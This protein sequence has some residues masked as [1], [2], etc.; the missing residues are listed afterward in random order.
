MSNIKNKC[1]E[2]LTTAVEN[3]NSEK[4]I[5]ICNNDE[6]RDCIKDVINE[7]RGGNDD[8]IFHTIANSFNN[9]SANVYKTLIK[10]GAD[11]TIKNDRG[12]T[13]V[14][15]LRTKQNDINE[16]KNGEELSF[17]FENEEKVYNDIKEKIN[18]IEG[19]ELNIDSEMEE[20]NYDNIQKEANNIMEQQEVNEEKSDTIKKEEI[21][22]VPI[23][24]NKNDEKKK[25]NAEILQKINKT[26]E[27]LLSEIK[28]T[29]LNAYSVISEELKSIDEKDT[30]LQKEFVTGVLT[31]KD[32]Y[33]STLIELASMGNY[34]AFRELFY[35]ALE[36]APDVV[37]TKYFNGNTIL[38]FACSFNTTDN[39]YRPLIGQSEIVEEILNK[40]LI[41]IETTNNDNE[42][43]L[44]AA[45][46]AGNYKMVKLLV[47]KNANVSAV[48]KNNETPLFA[49]CRKGDLETMK[50]LVNNGADIFT[51]NKDGKNLFECICSDN[52]VGDRSKIE[53]FLN[54]EVEKKK[55]VLYEEIND[56]IK[57]GN[58]YNKIKDIIENI[59]NEEYVQ[60]ILQREDTRSGET[61]LFEA[62][63]K[64][65]IDTVKLL[66]ERGANVFKM[67]RTNKGILDITTNNEV[68][69]YIQNIKAKQYY[70]R[71]HKYGIVNTGIAPVQFIFENDKDKQSINLALQLTNDNDETL[72]FEACRK[73]D[74]AL[75]DSL[76]QYGAGVNV[77]NK[78]GKTVID[79]LEKD[80]DNMNKKIIKG[81]IQEYIKKNEHNSKRDIITGDLQDIG[82]TEE[83]IENLYN[84]ISNYVRDGNKTELI[85]TLNKSENKPYIKQALNTK[86]TNGD[87]IFQLACRNGFDNDTLYLLAQNGADIF[88]RNNLNKDALDNVN[89]PTTKQYLDELRIQKIKSQAEEY[90]INKDYYNLSLLVR[91]HGETLWKQTTEEQLLKNVNENE[92]DIISNIFTTQLI[93]DGVNQYNAYDKALECILNQDYYNLSLILNK[94]R[95]DIIEKTHN[96]DESVV[97]NDIPEYFAN[98]SN[99]YKKQKTN[100]GFN[101]MDVAYLCNDDIVK[102]ILDTSSVYKNPIDLETLDKTTKVN[103]YRNIIKFYIEN[104]KQEE[105]KTILKNTDRK[106]F[107][108]EALNTVDKNGETLLFE[109]CKQ[110]NIEIVELLVENGADISATNNSNE[111]P[112][113]EACRQGNIEIVELLVKNGA[114]ISV[115]NNNNET[116]LFEACRQQNTEVIDLLVKNGADVT[117][118]NNEGKQI[119][120]YVDMSIDG[121]CNKY[122]RNLYCRNYNDAL[123]N[124]IKNNTF[125]EK[126]LNALSGTDYKDEI[127]NLQDNNGETLLF[128]ACKQG[129]IKVIDFLIKNGA[130]IY[131]QDLDDKNIFDHIDSGK[132][133][134]KDGVKKYLIG[135]K[136]KDQEQLKE[137]EQE[138]KQDDIL[139]NNAESDF[140]QY[141]E[142]NLEEEQVEQQMEQSTQDEE[143]L[144]QQLQQELK[145]NTEI[146]NNQEKVIELYNNIDKLIKE[147]KYGEIN[148]IINDEKNR[149]FIR[150]VLKWQDENGET[151]L[152]QACRSGN[153]QV[154]ELLLNKE[155]EFGVKSIGILNKDGKSI[156]NV[157]DEEIKRLGEENSS[158]IKVV[159]GYIHGYVD[160]Y[161]K[162]NMPLEWSEIGKDIKYK[163]K[164]IANNNDVVT[165]K[166]AQQQVYQIA[167]YYANNS[168]INIEQ[169]KTYAISD[170]H[171]DMGALLESLLRSGIVEFVNPEE[172]CIVVVNNDNPD[173]KILIPN[174]K[175]TENSNGNKLVVLGDII[176]RGYQSDSCMMLMKHLMNQQTQQKSNNIIFTVGNHEDVTINDKT[177]N[178]YFLTLDENS[179]KQGENKDHN[180]ARDIFKDMV[181]QN[182][183]LFCYY[184]ESTNTIYSHVP[185]DIK[186]TV[187]ALN[188]IQNNKNEF[189]KQTQ[190]NIDEILNGL[191]KNPDF[192]KDNKEG[193]KRLVDVFNELYKYKCEYGNEELHYNI[194][195]KEDNTG[196]L[197]NRDYTKDDFEAIPGINCVCGHDPKKDDSQEVQINKDGSIVNVDTLR[198]CG[199][200][201]DKNKVGLVEILQGENGKLSHKVLEDIGH[202]KYSEDLKTIET[203]N[204]T[205][206]VILQNNT[207]FIKK[208]I[209]SLVSKDLSKQEIQTDNVKQQ[210]ENNIKTQLTKKEKKE[211]KKE[212]KRAEKQQKQE[213]KEIKKREKEEKKEQKNKE[214]MQNI[215]TSGGRDSNNQILSQRKQRHRFWRFIKRIIDPFHLFFK[216]DD[217]S[218]E[219]HKT[220]TSYYSNNYSSISHSYPEANKTV[221]KKRGIK[222]FKESVQNMWKKHKEN[223][224]IK[225]EIKELNKELIKE[226]VNNDNRI[227][228]EK[229][230]GEINAIYFNSVAKYTDEQYGTNSLKSESVV[231]I[232]E[233]LQDKIEKVTKRI[234]NYYKTY[235]STNEQISIDEGTDKR[236]YG[237]EMY[238]YAMLNKLSKSL[239]G[240]DTTDPK[241]NN[242]NF[243]KEYKGTIKKAKKE[244][245]S[246][247]SM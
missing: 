47:E 217:K 106:K 63:R 124:D 108:I 215:G 134:L 60:D 71:I 121:S 236:S 97:L 208:N 175:L 18:I 56:L 158:D 143:Q 152:F 154:V 235:K 184:D 166:D 13:V 182:Q 90:I 35:V 180:T 226:V 240:S 48:N 126:T 189:S 27:I 74:I 45:C 33:E 157:L 80:K 205:K 128:E 139:E 49:A 115:I 138:L 237:D 146:N 149:E 243:I 75:V 58:G 145:N 61:L 172:P 76:M 8:T 153:I 21:D 222:H 224:A 42:T 95:S 188:F 100:S 67:N 10:V 186:N 6:Y 96:G 87:N 199:Y 38:H 229:I 107:L 25:N 174:I 130:D 86:N 193:V 212:Q 2:E 227:E 34:N 183:M 206:P 204:E 41:N 23:Q 140:S 102:Q 82:Q 36:K 52:S 244:S 210:Q 4:F 93:N 26:Y 168:K 54:A 79:I 156:L 14:D 225:K 43:P 3:G 66:V 111:T 16:G 234:D 117:I 9:L 129:N 57:G 238:N 233:K 69:K 110:G 176:D 125:D 112:L 159:R 196:L 195:E 105:L 30:E 104:N 127:L 15:I 198:S 191:N 135:Y 151:L 122:M 137:N 114:D 73:G 232:S 84:K 11:I 88:T 239:H 59:K 164:G 220:N 99:I 179:V 242:E 241:K 53:Q 203:I 29:E 221:T 133:Y 197:W 211:L 17:N 216:D 37:A 20:K 70:D 201:T 109:A 163:Q 113:F 192:F 131:L 247:M 68:K 142:E 245:S 207:V 92:K 171:G 150:D 40:K 148:N 169:N 155:E 187:N 218:K 119:F 39:I 141:V 81:M 161:V 144:Q 116:P 231:S 31:K 55:K 72:L 19:R 44:F 202:I 162:E 78:D 167:H 132:I 214:K 62:C 46:K 77:K 209:N 101:L 160:K 120:D 64:G 118:S 185:F 213:E 83:K 32:N 194:Y 103:N 246:T 94:Y 177:G 89:N 98:H 28:N 228:N 190:Q 85:R 200:T 165:H 1:Y 22:I 136:N 181:E 65:D 219:Q 5:Q 223:K 24:D 12:Q 123:K 170:T 91:Y 50:L 147:K 230:R 178:A 173:N 7:R 51:V